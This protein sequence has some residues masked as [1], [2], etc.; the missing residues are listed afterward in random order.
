MLPLAISTGWKTVIMIVAMIAVFYFFLI[1]PQ[2]QQAKKEAQ[3][4]NE[5]KKGDKVMLMGGIHATFVSSEQ[6]KALVEVAP[7]VRWKVQLSSINPISVPEK[8]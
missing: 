5:L 6:N 7:N 8:N 2:S 4:R 3:F 1:R